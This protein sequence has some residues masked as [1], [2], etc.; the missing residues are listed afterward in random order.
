MVAMGMN[1]NEM[2]RETESIDSNHLQPK[3]F[4]Q[5]DTFDLL[6]KAAN[7]NA[8][9]SVTD[10]QGTIIYV[11]DMFCQVSGYTRQELLGNSH[12]ILKSPS[13]T[14]E[15]VAELWG[16]LNQGAVWRGE[17]C[18]RSKDGKDY[19]ISSTIIPF[20]EED[21]QPRKYLA[22]EY[23]ITDM[24]HAKQ[25]AAFLSNELGE[26]MAYLRDL[27]YA[28]DQTA[29]VAV[30]NVAGIILQCNDTFC[31]VTGYDRE[32]IV[33]K[34][35]ALINSGEHKPEFFRELWKTI[36][37][38]KVWKGEICNRRKNGSLY[39]VDTTIIPFLDENGRPYRFLALR[40]EI[41]DKKLAELKIRR[42]NEE[43]E[44]KVLERTEELQ[45]LNNEK[46][47]IFAITAH[48]LKN[49]LSAILLQS[50]LMKR[51]LLSGEKDKALHIADNIETIT[52]RMNDI[53]CN[54][55][56]INRLESGMMKISP[57]EYSIHSILEAALQPYYQKAEKKKITL[58][59]TLKPDLP[60]VI[61][62]YTAFIRIM[63]NL[64]SNA[65]KYSPL[66]KSVYVS[67]HLLEKVQNEM[68][69]G[70]Q[71]IR[72]TIRDEGP[73][74]SEDDKSRLFHKFARLSARP[75]GGESS[76]GLGLSVVH[77]LA[78]ILGG[79][80]TCESQLGMGATFFVDLPVQ[81][82]AL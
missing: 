22:F 54:L 5:D 37:S 26:N 33:G 72:F 62:D 44:Q 12:S 69:N 1:S 45:R 38:G 39:W 77:K 78:D 19:W 34:T 82:L 42:M 51:Y 80:V 48:D 18:N 66:G 60:T 16:A 31:K 35:H 79:K 49:P 8:L 64:I 28:I 73:G 40:F 25:K 11:N 43:L 30:T 20:P 58:Q 47:E 65:V 24:V 13:S 2:N 10:E 14:R 7:T 29:I 57:A 75:T 46:D 71:Y 50:A 27:Q 21:N 67:A 56:D 52:L 55:L 70:R 9:I 74:F 3:P 63:D 76:T 61:T 59:C 36:V 68:D 53:V 6:R 41:T 17:I 23:L 15:F 4:T 32:E 81:G